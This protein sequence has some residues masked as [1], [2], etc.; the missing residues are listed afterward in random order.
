MMERN[1]KHH[2]ILETLQ[3]QWVQCRKEMALMV[4]LLENCWEVAAAGPSKPSVGTDHPCLRWVLCC[5]GDTRRWHQHCHESW[6]T[7]ALEATPSPPGSTNEAS[8]CVKYEQG[9]LWAT[10]HRLLH[11]IGYHHTPRVT[12]ILH[13][14][15]KQS[16]G[17]QHTPWVTSILHGL[18]AHSMGYFHAPWVTST[19]HGLLPCS[20]GYQHTPWVTSTL[21]GL[22]PC[23]MGYQHTPCVT[24]MLHGLPAHSMG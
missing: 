24:S 3:R 10:F 16:I 4:N 1:L 18:P 22:L 11:S 12:I 8:P 21:N 19:L 23:S 2:K 14:L 7:S 9:L 17:Y 20:M 13:G 6:E 15:P 5:H